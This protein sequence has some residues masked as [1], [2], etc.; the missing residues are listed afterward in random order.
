MKNKDNALSLIALRGWQALRQPLLATMFGLLIGA[1]VIIAC[2]QNP[3]VVYAELLEKSFLK[4]YYLFSTLTRATPIII[5]S[6]AIGVC[7]RAGYINLGVEGQMVTG[8]LMAT[9]VALYMPGPRIL[10]ALV[11]WLVGMLSGALYALIPAVLCVALALLI[12]PSDRLTWPRAWRERL[13]L[14]TRGSPSVR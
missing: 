7:W 8:T 3:L 1:V 11:A 4:P 5:C 14:R 6:M 2:G 13:M 9:V 12:T 10:V